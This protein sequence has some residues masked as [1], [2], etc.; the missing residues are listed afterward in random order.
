MPS[1][2]VH[3]KKGNVEALAKALDGGRFFFSR[4]LDVNAQDE[5]RELR[6]HSAVLR[7]GINFCS[8]LRTAT[9]RF[10]TL[11]TESTRMWCRSCSSVARKSTWR[12]R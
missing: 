10:T 8:K 7:S 11:S 4:K 12:T 2:H 1:W 5:V 6:A 3:A 9:R